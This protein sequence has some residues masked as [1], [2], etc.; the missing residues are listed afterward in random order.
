MNLTGRRKRMQQRWG[1]NRTWRPQLEPRIYW[2]E[3]RTYNNRMSSEPSIHWDDGRGRQ[4]RPIYSFSTVALSISLSLSAW[5]SSV[6]RGRVRSFEINPWKSIGWKRADWDRYWRPK[7]GDRKDLVS[8]SVGYQIGLQFRFLFE[9]N[10]IWSP[11]LVSDGHRGRLGSLNLRPNIF[12][13]FT[14]NHIWTLVSNSETETFERSLIEPQK[15]FGVQNQRP[16]IILVSS[17]D[18]NFISVSKLDINLIPLP[19][20]SEFDFQI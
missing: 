7:I 14:G 9:S 16:K 20:V 18:H 12:S 1:W 11:N 15:N 2:A 3:V 10:R 19:T 17:W 8:K 4:W 5:R 6:E 13:V